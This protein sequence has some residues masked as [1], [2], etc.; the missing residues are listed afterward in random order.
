M[1]SDQKKAASAASDAPTR[2]PSTSSTD[3]FPPLNAS[4]RRSH[5]YRQ[6]HRAVPLSVTAAA[7]KDPSLPPTFPRASA[8]IATTAEAT[9]VAA[10]ATS[11]A[12]EAT[13]VAAE[14]TS[15]A[16]VAT[17]V[18]AVATSVAAAATSVPMAAAPATAIFHTSSTSA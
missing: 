8:A 9:S 10:E 2:P 18:A 5:R 13:S 12:A 16:A 15:V 1:P 11:V 6:L 3:E 4:S 14:A 17:S 7:L